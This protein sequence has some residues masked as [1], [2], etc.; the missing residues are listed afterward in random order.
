MTAQVMAQAWP[1]VRLRVR[2]EQTDEQAARAGRWRPGP[3]KAATLRAVERQRC[4]SLVVRCKNPFT[5]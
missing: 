5:C 1:P 3:W 4:V 2:G